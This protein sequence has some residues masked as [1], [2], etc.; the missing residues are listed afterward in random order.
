MTKVPAL[1][2]AAL[3]C[4]APAAHA[5]LIPN[6][7]PFSAEV[8][9]GVGLPGGD[10]DDA[11]DAGFVASGNVTY[12]FFPGLGL[13]G[14]YAY[15]RFDGEGDLTI[16]DSGFGVGLRLEVPTPLIPIDPW[17]RGGVV[18]RTLEASGVAGAAGEESG[19]GFEAAAGLGMSL[20]P[21]VQLTPGIGM[22]KYD[23]DGVDVTLWKVDVGL[24][25][26]I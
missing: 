12:H 26:R 7:T 23:A 13:Y 21:K 9:G 19:T 8:R 4:A 18:F 6:L 25:V 11:A 3:L 22:V 14:E 17:I 5:Q 24:R 10:L 2:A 16:T 20:L 1:L 15:N